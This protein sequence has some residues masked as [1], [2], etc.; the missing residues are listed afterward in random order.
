MLSASGGVDEAVD[1]P[2]TIVAAESTSELDAIASKIAER[3]SF[4][5]H[6]AEGVITHPDDDALI[7]QT[8]KRTQGRATT[9][10]H[11]VRITSE[12]DLRSYKTELLL[13]AQPR[14]IDQRVLSL[15][16]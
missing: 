11:R 7:A 15:Q 4:A 3:L 6:I 10:M 5:P 12:Q 14:A 9:N 16:S 2:T 13:S 8:I 1:E